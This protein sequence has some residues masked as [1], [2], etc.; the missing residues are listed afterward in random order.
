MDRN[1]DDVPDKHGGGST[2]SSGDVQVLSFHSGKTKPQG[3]SFM[4]KLLHFTVGGS[5]FDPIRASREDLRAM[6]SS[7]VMSPF[8]IWT[9]T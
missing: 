5:H 1:D 8:I 3:D 9:V 2:Q 4:S 6:P 7:E